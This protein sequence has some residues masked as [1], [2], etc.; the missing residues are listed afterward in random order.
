[1]PTRRVR[2]HHSQTTVNV[3]LC[4][5]SRNTCL[6]LF[7]DPRNNWSRNTVYKKTTQVSAGK[8]WLS[9]S[10]THTHVAVSISGPH[11]SKTLYFSFS[12]SCVLTWYRIE[13]ETFLTLSEHNFS[14][15]FHSVLK[16]TQKA[17]KNEQV[18]C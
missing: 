12:I 7:G 14:L 4:K 15:V 11:K 9:L 13:L 3:W 1:M 10:L 17:N 5:S 6:E 18:A 16:F 8:N 2:G